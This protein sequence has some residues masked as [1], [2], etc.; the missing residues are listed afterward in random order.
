ML[1]I[2]DLSTDKLYVSVKRG[3]LIVSRDGQE[4]GRVALDDI[5]AVI[6]HAH[7]LTWSNTVFV[8]LADRSVPIVL[9]AQNHAPIS[10]IWPM[11]GHHLQG[12][13]LN[14]QALATRPLSKRLWRDFVVSKIRMQGA[15][16]ASTGKEAGAFARLAQSVR[17]G[18]PR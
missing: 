17:S 1:R 4:F 11:A 8:R 15:V 12:K 9:C 3:F 13:R 7:A 2:I 6:A 5:G 14:A 16:L 18:D 10:C